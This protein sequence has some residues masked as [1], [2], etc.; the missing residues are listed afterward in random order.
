MGR[1]HDGVLQGFGSGSAVEGTRQGVDTVGTG[2]PTETLPPGT[3]TKVSTRGTHLDPHPWGHRPSPRVKLCYTTH[4][5]GRKDLVHQTDQSPTTILSQLSLNPLSTL[6]Y[7]TLKVNNHL[8][9]YLRRVR[10]P[11]KYR[12]SEDTERDREEVEQ[13]GQTVYT[14]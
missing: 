12:T 9:L 1:L 14:G 10:N 8:H 7:Q 4:T 5:P 2:P 11:T 6:T 3:T 13:E